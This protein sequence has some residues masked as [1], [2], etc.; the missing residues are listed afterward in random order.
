M[1]IEKSK[2]RPWAQQNDLRVTFDRFTVHIR[3][4]AILIAI[5]D[6]LL[7]KSTANP[8]VKFKWPKTCS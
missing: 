1:H 4:N 8:N 5:L 3:F 2:V 7:V 6:A